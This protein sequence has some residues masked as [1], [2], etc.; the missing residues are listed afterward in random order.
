MS[1]KS[2][3]DSVTANLKSLQWIVTTRQAAE[4]H[5]SFLRLRASCTSA[6]GAVEGT[7]TDGGCV[8]QGRTSREHGMPAETSS[9]V[10][11]KERPQC[12]GEAL[13][14]LPCLPSF[15]LFSLVAP[16]LRLAPSFG[17]VAVCSQRR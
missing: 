3:F 15:A 17:D 4:P 11:T 2:T 13:L 7:G 9:L 14:L 8:R 10:K 16:L 6:A 5:G 12:F 1:A